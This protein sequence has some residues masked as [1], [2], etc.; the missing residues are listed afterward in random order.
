MNI[1]FYI[2]I[3][4]IF[5]LI[6]THTLTWTHNFKGEWWLQEM[7]RLAKGGKFYTEYTKEEQIIWKQEV[8]VDEKEVRTGGNRY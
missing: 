1:I 3:K 6:H 4:S 2:Y 5:K 8:F 7:R